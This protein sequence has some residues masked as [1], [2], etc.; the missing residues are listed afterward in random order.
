MRV[1]WRRKG[2]VTPLRVVLPHLCK[3]RSQLPS[4]GL[5][6]FA[7]FHV[8]RELRVNELQRVVH[9][10]DDLAALVVG[11]VVEANAQ[12]FVEV[13]ERVDV[14]GAEIGRH[15]LA[16]DPHLLPGEAMGYDGTA[17]PHSKR[18]LPT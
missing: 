8:C 6:G 4:S 18:P 3:Q 10:A 5:A 17:W 7:R 11:P 14:V 1:D 12:Q 13:P 2:V 16:G 9:R 15:C